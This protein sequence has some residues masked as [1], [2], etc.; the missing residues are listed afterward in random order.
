MH[1]TISSLGL[2]DDDARTHEEEGSYKPENEDKQLQGEDAHITSVSHLIS[3][4]S[5]CPYLFPYFSIVVSW[6]TNAHVCVFVECFCLK[7]MKFTPSS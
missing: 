5:V 7:Q 1:C 3:L 6:R 4:L 2:G